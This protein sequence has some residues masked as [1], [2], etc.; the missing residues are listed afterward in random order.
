[1]TAHG[2]TDAQFRPINLK[3]KFPQIWDIMQKALEEKE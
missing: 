3:K 2:F 1:M